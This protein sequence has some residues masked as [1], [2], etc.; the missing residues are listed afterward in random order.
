MI[1]PSIFFIKNSRRNFFLCSRN[2]FFYL[3][4]WM[5][6]FINKVSL[7][8]LWFCKAKVLIIK[9][10]YYNLCSNSKIPRAELIVT[11]SNAILDLI[12]NLRSN[13]RLHL[14]NFD[15]L[16]LHVVSKKTFDILECFCQLKCVV[17]NTRSPASI[18]W[19]HIEF[20]LEFKLKLDRKFDLKFNIK[21]DLKSS[22][23]RHILSLVLR[24]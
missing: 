10:F 24:K 21:P 13:S 7:F 17:N 4:S 18:H 19:L 16:S 11:R 1:E 2:S 20:N 12:S 22:I 8:S 23:L 9:N 5:W 3:K 6:S 15:G 14:P